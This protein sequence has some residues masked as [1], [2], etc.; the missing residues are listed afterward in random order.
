MKSPLSLSRRAIR[1]ICR[2]ASLPRRA[3]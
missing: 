2:P 1:P 3:I